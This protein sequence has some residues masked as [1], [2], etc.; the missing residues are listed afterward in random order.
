MMAADRQLAERIEGAVGEL[1]RVIRDLRNYIFGLRPG[2][3]ADRQLDQALKELTDEF[4]SRTG[5]VA[6]LTVDRHVAAELASR[7]GDLVQF[8]REALSNVGRHAAAATCRVSLVQVGDAAMLEIDDDGQ[9]FD[10]AAAR[11]S[12]NGLI[13]LEERA[14]ALG[15]TMTIESVPGEGA[16]L[17]VTIPLR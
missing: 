7:A 1:D 6:V 5:V 15:G 3:L 4:G 14:A 12:G 16:R 10:P 13:N 17:R 8:T 2:I 11:G 9:G